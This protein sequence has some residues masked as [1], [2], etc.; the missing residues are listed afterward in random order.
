MSHTSIK[1]IIGID[2]VGRGPLAGP[3]LVGAVCVEI[4]NIKVKNRQVTNSSDISLELKKFFRGA[5]DSKKLSAK[6]REEIFQKIKQAGKF[7]LLQYIVINRGARIVDK[8]GI[9]AAIV[10]CIAECLKKLKVRPKKSFIFLDGGLQA[11][12]KFIFQKTIIGGDDKKMIISLA[13]IVAKVSRDAL[14]SRLAK[15][16]PRYGFE[17]HK[18][19]GTKK[20]RKAIK[21]FGVSSIHRKTWIS[22]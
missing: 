7:N 21:K 5:R 16:F 8:I 12:K 2:E 6:K 4:G 15:K 13:S 11:P 1:T 22:D 19:Y 17:V 18:G 9:N 10:D 20:H 14:M 3:V